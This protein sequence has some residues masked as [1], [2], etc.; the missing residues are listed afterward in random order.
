MRLASEFKDSPVNFIAGGFYQNGK[1][2]HWVTLRTNTT[3]GFPAILQRAVH[4]SD[5]RS[6]SA[7]GHLTWTVRPQ[8]EI[9]GGARWTHEKR[10]HVEINQNP[11]NRPLG[12]FGPHRSEDI[13]K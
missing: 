3:F 7:L 13:L 4:Q 11:A 2:E 5:I 6:I 8:L 10:T 1:R 9:S 12:Q